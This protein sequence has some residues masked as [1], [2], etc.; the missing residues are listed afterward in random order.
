MLL[1]IFA[2]FFSKKKWKTAW[3]GLIEKPVWT[4]YMIRIKKESFPRR[5]DRKGAKTL[6]VEKPARRERERESC[7]IE[8]VGN[9]DS[10]GSRAAESGGVYSDS[11]VPQCRLL[12]EAWTN[13]RRH[14][15]VPSFFDLVLWVSFSDCKVPIFIYKN[16]LLLCALCI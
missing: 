12:R 6:S 11:W 4:R 14:L 13:W 8:L 3:T 16:L 10:C 9:N 7:R 2:F 15:R 1:V 5:G